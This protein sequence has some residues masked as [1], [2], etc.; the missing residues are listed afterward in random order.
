MD[1]RG[2]KVDVTMANVGTRALVEQAG[3]R[4]ASDTASVVGVFP[5]VLMRMDLR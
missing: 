5:R 4:K 1:H 3:F 2:E